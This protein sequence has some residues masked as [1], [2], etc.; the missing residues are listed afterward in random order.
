VKDGIR[1][2]SSTLALLGILLWA[3]ELRAADAVQL[4]YTAV[5][6]CATEASFRAAVTERGG[7]FDVARSPDSPEKLQVSI[8]R[9][10]RGFRGSLQSWSGGSSSSVREL[11][12][13]SCQE[14]LD[15]LAVVGA[16]ALR[17][18]DRAAS[19]PTPPAEPKPETIP[20]AIPAPA[21]DPP[22]RLRAS[23][24]VGNQRV[25]VSAGTL[26]FEKVRGVS[27]FAGAELGLLPKTLVPRLDLSFDAANFVTTP[28]GKS[29]LDGV[30]PRIRLSYFGQTSEHS[31]DASATL[32]GASFGM[33]LCWS[34]TYDTRG[35]AALLC[36]EYGAGVL[37]VASKDTSGGETR[38]KT[39]GFGSAG[40]GLETHYNLGS[41]FHVGLKL[42]A[43]ALINPVSAERADGSQIFHSSSFA[44]YG[45]LGFGLHF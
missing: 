15:A 12:G 24:S 38:H 29:Y 37:K 45:M 44:G 21:P 25:Q 4:E 33:A 17:A 27:L 23:G 16:L 11:H 19:A 36:L 42:G 20:V 40:A 2:R 3:A 14:V 9:A 6:G 41:L 1:A 34:P 35:F 26:S 18:G 5:D 30:L 32:E 28:S 43:D 39:T 13:A 7:Q 10:E 22:H 31:G 8:E